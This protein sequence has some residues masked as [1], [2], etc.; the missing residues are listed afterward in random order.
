MRCPKCANIDDKV[1]DSRHSR[2]GSSIR[3][4]R[5]CLSCQTRFTSYEELERLA[6]HVIKRDGRR[7]PFDRHKLIASL[8]K[9]CEKRP[10]GIEAIERASDDI[11]AELEKRDE[12]EIS[13]RV[14][15]RRTMESLR[16]LDEIAYI[17][18]ASVYRQFEEIGDFL[19]EIEKMEKTTPPSPNQRELF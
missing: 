15:G 7:E 16:L 11:I 6:M 17:R 2:D 10:V 13:T 8:T 9:A 12:R 18:Y 1:I 4:R 3:R 5:E 19:Q 14:V